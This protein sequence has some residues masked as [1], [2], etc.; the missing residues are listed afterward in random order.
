MLFNYP[1]V[2]F[3]QPTDVILPSGKQYVL[4]YDG[5]GNLLAVTMPGQGRHHFHELTTLGRHR[6]MYTAPEARGAFT[7]DFDGSGKTIEVLYPTGSKRILYRY[8]AYSRV[9]LEMFDWSRIHYEYYEEQGILKSIMLNNRLSTGSSATGFGDYTCKLLYKPAAALIRHHAVEFNDT[10]GFELWNAQYHYHYDTH[11][12]VILR[13]TILGSHTFR[14]VNF[15]YSADTGRLEGMKSF[16]FQYPN[17]DQR[18]ETVRDENIYIVREMDGYG[19]RSD[20]WYRFNNHVAFTLEMTYDTAGRVK[21]WR[22]QIGTSDLKAYDYVYDIDGNLLE[23]QLNGQG[24]W[25]YEYDAD[26]NLVKIIHHGRENVLIVDNA[27]HVQSMD[28]G[29]THY[30]FDDDGFMATR[31]GE[32]FEYNSHGLLVRAHEAGSYDV[33]YYYDG[34]DRLVARRDVIGGYL[35]QFFYADTSRRT[36]LTHIYDHGADLVTALYH[37]DKDRLF[38]IEQEGRYFYIALDPMGTPV[39]VFNSMGSVVKH[40]T[41]DPLGAKLVD[42]APDFS[43]IVGFQGGIMDHIT[44]LVHFHRRVYDPQTGRWTGGYYRDLID[45]VNKIPT[46]PTML[47]QYQHQHIVNL[48]GALVNEHYTGVYERAGYEHYTGVY[49]RAGYEHYTGVYERAGDE[50]TIS[51]TVQDSSTLL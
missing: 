51:D 21:Q 20:S 33:R 38:A 30:T 48:E 27:N 28:G 6:R 14:P 10:Q 50:H 31:D 7:I 22:R 41:Y 9:T 39:V 24:A 1:H 44:S 26:S 15:S 23:V 46:N 4:R 3:Q 25:R 47:N 11:F 18:Q 36:R 37:D 8:D 34:Y 29:K 35:V 45:N 12:R 32:Q 49:E 5:S 19:R 42:S 43:F 2:L 40:M 13:E 17:T 16:V